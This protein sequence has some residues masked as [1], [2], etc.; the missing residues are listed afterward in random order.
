[1]QRTHFSYRINPMIQGQRSYSFVSALQPCSFSIFFSSLM[2][3]KH[4]I[5]LWFIS[6]QYFISPLLIK[7]WQNITNKQ[8]K[9]KLKKINDDKLSQ[10]WPIRLVFKI[11]FGRLHCVRTTYFKLNSTSN[12]IRLTEHDISWNL[13]RQNKNSPNKKQCLFRI[14]NKA[15]KKSSA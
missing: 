3:M 10:M 1:M 12:S 5:F 4:V 13:V 9:K 7:C 11:L 2:E 6:K 14:K 8:K 15:K